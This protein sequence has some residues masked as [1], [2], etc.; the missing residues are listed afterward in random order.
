MDTATTPTALV[1][2]AATT[3]DVTPTSPPA[4]S[5]AVPAIVVSAELVSTATATPPESPISPEFVADAAAA[6][7]VL[8]LALS[9]ALNPNHLFQDP[10]PPT[11]A[12]FTPLKYESPTVEEA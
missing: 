2:R 10:N 11:N 1:P 4:S 3:D 9:A 8:A 7:M 5:T 12:F 6:C